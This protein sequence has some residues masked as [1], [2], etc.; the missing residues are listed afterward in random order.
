MTVTPVRPEYA[1]NDVITCLVKGFPEPEVQW[2]REGDDVLTVTQSELIVTDEM[3]MSDVNSWTC[4][5]H[6]ELNTQP[7]THNIEF[8]VIAATGMSLSLCLSL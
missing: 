1:V 4:S 5:A 7:L 2:V 8:T 3:M 6:N